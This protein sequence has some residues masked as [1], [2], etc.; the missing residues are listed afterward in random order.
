VVLIN[1]DTRSCDVSDIRLNDADQ[2]ILEELEEGRATAAYLS[3]RIDW[4]R[5]YI[6]QRLRRLDEHDIVENLESSGLY[7]LVTPSQ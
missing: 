1:V 2:A 3:C 7:E 6:T 5:E 4:E